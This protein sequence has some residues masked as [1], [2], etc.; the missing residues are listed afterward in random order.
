MIY[1]ILAI[2]VLTLIIWSLRKARIVKVCPICAATVITWAGGL[3]AIHFQ[4]SFANPLVIAVLMGASLG[5]M[6]EKYG[7]RFGLIWKITMV[8]LGVIA[9]YFLVEP[10]SVYK[11]LVIAIVLFIYSFLASRSKPAIYDDRKD[12]FKE[13]C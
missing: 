1:Y 5:A 6:A 13:C 4:L 8:L 3:I 10:Q 11:G 9:I 7:N 2:T 12:I